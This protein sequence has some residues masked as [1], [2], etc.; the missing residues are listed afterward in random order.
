MILSLR[1]YAHTVLE[2]KMLVK[3]LYACI[4]SAKFRGVNCPVFLLATNLGPE[5]PTFNII[6]A[7]CNARKKGKLC[8]LYIAMIKMTYTAVIR[9]VL[10]FELFFYIYAYQDKIIFEYYSK[11]FKSIMNIH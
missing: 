9:F 1:H 10:I 6:F 4:N 3:L 5:I 11:S 8:K 2:K 7:E